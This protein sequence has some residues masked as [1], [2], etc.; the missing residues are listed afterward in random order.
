[1]LQFRTAR[2][3]DSKVRARNE[4]AISYYTAIELCD[5]KRKISNTIPN[6][7]A[8]LRRQLLPASSVQTHRYQ[9]TKL[10]DVTSRKSVIFVLTA[11]E[12]FNLINNINLCTV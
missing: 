9:R 6:N 7:K 3:D 8:T 4:E 2:P 12:T 5:S 10:Y 1:M 11:T